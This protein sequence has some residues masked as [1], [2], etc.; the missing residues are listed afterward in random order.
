MENTIERFNSKI[1]INLQNIINEV[2]SLYFVVENSFDYENILTQMELNELNTIKE[3]IDK[4]LIRLNSVKKHLKEKNF[5]LLSTLDIDGTLLNLCNTINQ[6]SL[7]KIFVKNKRF[8]EDIFSIFQKCENIVESFELYFIFLYNSY[9]FHLKT[10]FMH[11]CLE[12]DLLDSII[13]NK[14]SFINIK[15]L[16]DIIKDTNDFH[17]F[18]MEMFESI[19]TEFSNLKIIK[20]IEEYTPEILCISHENKTSN[21]LEFNAR[22]N[23]ITHNNNIVDSNYL[24]FLKKSKSNMYNYNINDKI[25]IN[26]DYYFNFLFTVTELF[27]KLD[28]NKQN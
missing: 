8:F 22:R 19:F 12:N 3:N 9:E 17:T 10:K 5:F 18:K 23:I 1:H 6:L 4:L 26:G 15:K 28:E 20:Y 16:K 25:K 11:V 7:M 27:R 14:D 24:D 2:K 21:I 13:V